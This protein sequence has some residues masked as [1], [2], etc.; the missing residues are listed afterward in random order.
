MNSLGDVHFYGFNNDSWNPNTYPTTRFLSE[1]GSISQP[2]LD[3]WQEV[4]QNASDL[5][6]DSLFI[7]HREHDTKIYHVPYV[8]YIFLLFYSQK[9]FISF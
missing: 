3:T 9:Y 4:T 8:N 2:S 5:E 7:K 1:T 6:Y